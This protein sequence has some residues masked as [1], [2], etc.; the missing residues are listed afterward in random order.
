MH[1]NVLSC[2]TGK[3]EV[4]KGLE[5]LWKKNLLIS[6][7]CEELGFFLVGLLTIFNKYAKLNF[8]FQHGDHAIH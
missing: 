7:V 4:G 1:L 3:E 8:E 6:Q 5:C 2:S